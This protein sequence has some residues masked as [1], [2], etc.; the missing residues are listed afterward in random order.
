MSEVTKIADLARMDDKDAIKRPL[1]VTV[2]QAQARQESP[3]TYKP[4]EM[5]ISQKIQV[6][7]ETGSCWAWANECDEL[8][9]GEVLQ[10]QAVNSPKGWGG[11]I[12]KRRA[13]YPPDLS[14][15]PKGM[16]IVGVPS[17]QQGQGDDPWF[18]QEE[19]AR[20]QTARPQ[21]QALPTTSPARP[22]PTANGPHRWTSTEIERSAIAITERI[23]NGLADSEIKGVSCDQLLQCAQALTSTI[24]IGATKNDRRDNEVPSIL[25]VP[26]PVPERPAPEAPPFEVGEADSMDWGSFGEQ[27]GN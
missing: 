16:S 25:L 12:V 17:G 18:M 6:S 10:L 23:F 1:R 5:R 21:Q 24:L 14:F 2:R 15:Y 19:P 7:D 3:N 26:E 11:C 27:E 8:R 13:G 22:S 9:V 20:A 4:G